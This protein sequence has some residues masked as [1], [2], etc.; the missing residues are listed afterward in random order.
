MAR[1]LR[2]SAGNV[3]IE[4]TLALPVL[5]LLFVGL[6]DLGRYGLQQSSMLEGARQG[7]QYGMLA[8]SDSANINTTA[9]NATGLAGV[10]AT[11][12]VFCECV[13]GTSVSCTTICAATGF[14]PKT[15]VTVTASKPFTSIL[16]SATLNFGSFGS[17]TPPTSTTAS[18]TMVAPLAN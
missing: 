1:P 8:P 14:S 11:N 18:V 12:T 16:A 17:W 10:T 13:S 4:F 5:C 6:I 7:A 9:E 15:Y 3:A 2:D